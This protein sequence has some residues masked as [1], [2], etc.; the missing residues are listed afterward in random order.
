MSNSYFISTAI[1]YVN[2]APHIGH[3]LEYIETDAMARYQRLKGADVYFLSGSDENSL[4]NVQ[5]AEAAGITVKELVDKNSRLFYN[6][7]ELLNI[8][9]NGF[10]RTTEKR[11]FEGA[12]KLWSLCKKE[13]IYKKK[14]RG[15][16]CVGCEAY[17]TE[18]EL[19][20]GLCP[21][22][23]KAP[24]VVEEENY[25]FALSNYEKELEELVAS[26]T[27]KIIPGFRKNEVLGFIRNG[28]E[29]FSISRD[30]KRAH[31]WGVP[32]PGDPS[33]IMYVWVDALSNY[34]T[35]LDFATEGEL[36]RR[37]WLQPDNSKR[38]VVHVIGKGIL[39]FHAIYWIALLLS[40]GVPLPTQ[41]FI[42]GYITL[43]GEKMAKSTGNVLNPVELVEKFGVDPVRYF[44]LGAVSSYHD[45]D[46]SEERF[47][48]VYNSE[49]ANGVGNLFSRTLAMAEK[50]CSGA[51]PERSEDPFNTSAFW[52]NYTEKM[53]A[54]D[55][56]G[57]VRE[58]SSLVSACD[59]KI[60]QEKPWAMVK[61]GKDPSTLLYSILE[62][63]RHIALALLPVIPESAEKLL[64]QLNINPVSL[65]ALDQEQPWGKLEPGTKVTKG[66]AIFP[67][68]Q[69]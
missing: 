27:L 21:E 44:F 29:D 31:G 32:V 7:G 62:T 48:N 47:I 39:R 9:F 64:G 66:S 37:Y 18:D 53:E 26:D 1:P 6:F 38:Q 23:R 63:M 54:F 36:Y 11:H 33:Q 25:F 50:Y 41:E 24:E 56:Q 22:H 8:S 20:N 28:L 46:F 55:F 49:L 68:L 16:Y 2:G 65:S 14:Y 59:L 57:A 13:D 3:A 35:G 67:K 19:D 34:I 40:A 52:E 45:G 4:K 69:A 17:Y 42:H 51:V 43:E 61:E 10:I 60:S 58:I 12:Q 15:L 5:A 30:H